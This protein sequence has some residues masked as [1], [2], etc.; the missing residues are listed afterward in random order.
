M[1]VGLVKLGSLVKSVGF[2]VG[3]ILEMP[4][5]G[6]I[7]LV[8]NLVVILGPSVFFFYAVQDSSFAFYC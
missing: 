8:V 4:L 7:G 3:L 1:G 6:P 5:V 2:F